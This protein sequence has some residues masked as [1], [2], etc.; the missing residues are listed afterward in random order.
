MPVQVFDMHENRIILNE[1]KSFF[2][3]DLS[4]LHF[5][6]HSLPLQYFVYT[7]PVLVNVTGL[8]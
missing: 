6:V 8:P 7:E 3:R 5:D 4:C 2:Q 1:I